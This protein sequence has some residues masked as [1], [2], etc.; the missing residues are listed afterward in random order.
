E[1]EVAFPDGDGQGGVRC[2]GHLPATF[3]ALGAGQ[4]TEG[5][6]QGR[7]VRSG[8]QLEEHGEGQ[9]AEASQV[10]AQSGPGGAE[11]AHPEDGVSGEGG[12]QPPGERP[13]TRAGAA[14]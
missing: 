8:A 9:G 5:R 3:T 11:G 12:T 4:L 10:R 1:G 2:E 14:S 7:A 13:R 6:E